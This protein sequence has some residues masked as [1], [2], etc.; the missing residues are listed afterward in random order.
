MFEGIARDYLKQKSN[1][2]FSLRN[3]VKYALRQYCD[4][5]GL[6]KSILVEEI[7]QNFLEEHYGKLVK[8]SK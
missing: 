1:E 5:N 3:N 6:N 8:K 7:I 4:E 2:T